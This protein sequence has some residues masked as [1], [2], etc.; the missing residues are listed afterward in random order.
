MRLSIEIARRVLHR[1]LS[2]DS[3]AIEALVSAALEKLKGQE[4]YRVRTHPDLEKVVRACLDRTG[5][6]QS[7]AVIGDP[8]QPK[9]GAVFEVNR[10]S[11]DSSVETQ[12]AE[13]E[14]GIFEQLE[15]NA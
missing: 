14:R 5:R 12:L 13:I 1:E 15:L 9:G 4:V 10:G 2:L 7:V 6:G 8:V 11:L 3:S